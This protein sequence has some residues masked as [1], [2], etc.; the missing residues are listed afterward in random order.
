[1]KYTFPCTPSVCLPVKGIDEVFPV[2]R[3]YCVAANYAQH[4]IEMGSDGREPPAFF[5]KPVDVLVPE[6]GNIHYPS[7]TTK[8]QHEVELVVALGRGGE[9]IPV[10]EALEH[11]YGYAIGIDLTRRDLQMQAKENGKPWEMSKAFEQSAPI[12]HII[13][14]SMLGH[15]AE[16]SIWLTVNGVMKQEGDL[17]QMTWSVAEI[18]ANL[19]SYIRL[20]AGD[21]IFTGTP[22]GVSTI[23]S[24][25]RIECGMSGCDS[26]LI[27]IV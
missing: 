1:M 22:S 8:L 16:G 11:V 25:D 17:S 23:V 5:S 14:A 15:P 2:R 12:G 6:G 27:N 21:L 26:L 3:V 18:I 13:P 9:N 7:K 19:S 10:D 4:A 24:G 20:S